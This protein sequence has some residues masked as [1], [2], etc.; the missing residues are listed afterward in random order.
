M[1]TVEVRTLEQYIRAAA[2]SRG[3]TLGDL[4]EA[5]DT[6]RNSLKRRYRNPE[7]ADLGDFIEIGEALG[8]S[9]A[10]TQNM[11]DLAFQQAKQAKQTMAATA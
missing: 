10:E 2:A 9:A 6:N 8:L 11:L 1:T 3:M 7:S 5:L 4:C